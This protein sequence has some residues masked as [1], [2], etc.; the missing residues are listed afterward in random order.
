MAI[1]LPMTM[2]NRW[3][4]A[5]AGIRV[6]AV[7]TGHAGKKSRKMAMIWLYIRLG[8][9][10]GGLAIISIP[11]MWHFLLQHLYV[12]GVSG[13]LKTYQETHL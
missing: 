1:F 4:G 3:A 7:H 12:K 5:A 2:K 11:V 10:S 13:L 6:A 9:G 8:I